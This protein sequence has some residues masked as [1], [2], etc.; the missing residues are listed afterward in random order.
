MSSYFFQDSLLRP[1]GTRIYLQ[2]QGEDR[3]GHPTVVLCDGLGCDGFAWKYLLPELRK[4]HRVVRW[5][6]RGHGQ[7]S[8]PEDRDR[9]GMDFTCEDLAAV[10][11]AVNVRDA[12]LFGHSMGVQVALE[13]HR[14][15]PE[16][17]LGLVLMCGSYGH[18]LDTF[19]DSTL[20]KSAL[21]YLRK[22]VERFPFATRRVT[23][24]F[25]RTE[26]AVELA[27]AVELN[28]EMM[29]GLMMAWQFSNSNRLAA[30]ALPSRT[31]TRWL[32]RP[33]PGCSRQVR[34]NSSAMWLP[35]RFANS[36]AW[37]G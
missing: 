37:T 12:V 26:L 18:P 17:V 10:L 13:F 15:H 1:D 33:S 14:R 30:P 20:L 5:H 11:D 29:K 8:V 19:H 27:L 9:I 36:A 6:Y 3:G 16:R 2:V 25:M 23:G 32:K 28:R 24:L 35:T 4:S 34:C 21:P 31:I 22:V 7:S